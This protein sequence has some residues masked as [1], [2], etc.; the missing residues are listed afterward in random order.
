MSSTV[1]KTGKTLLLGA[2]TMLLASGK[3]PSVAFGSMSE[4]NMA[5]ILEL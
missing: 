1:V 2:A 3:A 5:R 4:D